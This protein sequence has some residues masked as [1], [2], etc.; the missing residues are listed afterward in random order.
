MRPRWLATATYVFSL[1]ASGFFIFLPGSSLREGVA[2]VLIV[3]FHVFLAVGSLISLGG[4]MRKRSAIE[5]TGIPLVVTAMLAYTVL[6]FA[7]AWAGESRS[8]GAAVGIGFLLLS[9]ATG[10]SGRCWE[11][12]SIMNASV[13][14]YDGRSRDG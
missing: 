4:A 13:D 12:I 2:S 14:S 10:L 11:C 5:A 7:S 9:L 8:P 3:A 6:L 1:L